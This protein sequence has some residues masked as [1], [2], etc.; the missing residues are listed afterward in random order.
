MYTIEDKKIIGVQTA[1]L[2]SSRS[3]LDILQ[4][5]PGRSATPDRVFDQTAYPV[6]ANGAGT[7]GCIR[8][9]KIQLL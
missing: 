5:I 4:K 9:T 2:L 1:D 8:C 7:A 3:L 6:E